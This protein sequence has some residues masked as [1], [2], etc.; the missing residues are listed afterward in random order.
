MC[1]SDLVRATENDSF[2]IDELLAD[3]EIAENC[4]REDIEKVLEP[5][6]YLGLSSKVALSVRDKV[7]AQ[8]AK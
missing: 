7:Q 8:L 3:K 1:S 5:A 4:S 6:G 2:L